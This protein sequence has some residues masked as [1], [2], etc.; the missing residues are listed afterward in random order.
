[1]SSASGTSSNRL[2]HYVER[3]AARSTP[4]AGVWANWFVAGNVL[5]SPIPGRLACHLPAAMGDRAGSGIR[6][7]RTSDGKAQRQPGP[8]LR[9]PPS[10]L[11]DCAGLVLVMPAPPLIG[12]GL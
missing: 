1:M 9:C 7:R 3:E 4:S 6:F 11:L 8:N 10:S 12:W 2:Y 5:T